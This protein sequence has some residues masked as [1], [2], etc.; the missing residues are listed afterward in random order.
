MGRVHSGPWQIDDRSFSTRARNT[1]VIYSTLR[2][3]DKWI[4][5]ANVSIAEDNRE[6]LHN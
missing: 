5:M 3:T 1:G 6:L 4:Q 2:E